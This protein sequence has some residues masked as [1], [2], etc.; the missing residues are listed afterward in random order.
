MGKISSDK[1]YIRL[2]RKSKGIKVL[3]NYIRDNYSNYYSSSGATR[4]SQSIKVFSYNLVNVV[5]N[6]LT[7]VYFPSKKE[8]YTSVIIDGRYVATGVG[9]QSTIKIRDMLIDLGI[10]TWTSGYKYEDNQAKGY[11][12][13][14]E[15][16]CNLVEDLVDLEKVNIKPLNNSLILKDLDGKV[17]TFKRNKVA[18][19]MLKVIN[20]YNALMENFKVTGGTVDYTE[21]VIE[22]H[23]LDTN[24]KRVFL[25][26]DTKFEHY[27][28][29]H[30]DGVSVQSIRSEH[31]QEI[32]IG[33]EKV[34][35]VDFVSLHP[36]MLYAKEGHE[37]PEGYDI[38]GL[39]IPIDCCYHNKEALNAY[40]N[41]IDPDY[42]PMRNYIKRLTLV[43]FNA[44][45]EASAAKVMEKEVREDRFKPYEDQKYFSL[46]DIS[47]RAVIGFIKQS[48]PVLVPYF[49]TDAGIH[50]MK[51]DSDI[52]NSIL[53]SFIEKG[54]PV[55]AV[56]DSCVVRERDYFTCVQTMKNAYEEVMGTSINCRLETK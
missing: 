5:Y 28:R 51:L 20:E 13:L 45:S 9:Y 30:Y 17:M 36:S 55:L 11:I 29:F 47:T 21:G 52:I 3:T 2:I 24:I 15:K 26:G 22:M 6:K 7:E 48:N 43:L 39:Q 35:E 31:R 56:H 38:Y 34:V 32:R 10:I 44:K 4:C 23:T 19:A 46:E 18:T 49:G 25:R 33:G 8:H 40:H 37:I 53:K 27:G 54:L 12:E 42:N 1:Y 50:L 14:T 41:Q 16:G